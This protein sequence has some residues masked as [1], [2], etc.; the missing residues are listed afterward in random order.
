MPKKKFIDKKK[1]VTFKLVH[2]SQR[3]PLIAD[4]NAPQH[5]LVEAKPMDESKRKEEQMKYG[6]YFDDDYNYLQHLRDVDYTVDWEEEKKIDKSKNEKSKSEGINLP[7]SVFASAVEEKEGLLNKAVLP[8]GPQ[9]DWDPD[10][11]AAMDEDFD[12]QDPN[13]QI[14]DDFVLQAECRAEDKD[15]VE[16]DNDDEWE[17]VCDDED[18]LSSNFSDEE[19]DEEEDDYYGQDYFSKEETKSHFTNY[20]MSS[21]I[22]RRNE[23][24]KT[25][26]ERFET[27]FEKEYAN[28][29]D[30]GALELDEITGNIDINKSKI[31]GQLLGEIKDDKQQIEND[32]DIKR[33]ILEYLSNEDKR[34]EEMCNIEINDIRKKGEN[35]RF[36]CESIISTYSNLYNHPKLICED[37]KIKINSKTGIPMGVLDKPGLTAKK[38]AKLDALNNDIDNRNSQAK[39]VCSRQSRLTTLSIRSKD[40]TTLERKARK[41]VLKQFRR[42][43]RSEKKLNKIAFKNEAIRQNKELKNLQ[44]NFNNIKLV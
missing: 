33:K 42:E 25:L 2:R 22:I 28:D 40:E 8:V 18:D 27:L 6:V 7:S 4:E 11:V 12:Y 43:R 26:D 9:P 41:S 39:S 17:D 14:D 35:D 30:I 13:N 20:S 19:S 5:V 15:K 36:D 38:L 37:K 1:A 23:G 31:L 21:S 24:L 10:I 32:E 16:D 3:D 34:P 29:C 44:N